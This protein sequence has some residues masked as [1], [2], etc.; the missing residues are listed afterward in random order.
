MAIGLGL[1]VAVVVAG[2]A[3]RDSIGFVVGG[4]NKLVRS[5]NRFKNAYA[6]D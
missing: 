3:A 5:R 2:C 1:M 6:P 4:Y